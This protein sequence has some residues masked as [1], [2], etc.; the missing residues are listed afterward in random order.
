GA[1]PTSSHVTISIAA[2]VAVAF[3]HPLC[4]LLEQSAGWPGVFLVNAP[5]VA[6]AFALGTT[7]LL[8]DPL[9]T[10]RCRASPR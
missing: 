9:R 6:V 10:D 7:L 2:Q 1:T 5:L 8:P 4:G 3:G